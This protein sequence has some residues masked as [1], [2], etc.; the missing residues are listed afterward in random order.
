MT[1]TI[2]GTT[3][4]SGE[5]TVGRSA[6]AD[7]LGA[8]KQRGLAG[9]AGTCSTWFYVGDLDEWNKDTR[10]WD[11]NWE[12]DEKVL[13]DTDTHNDVLFQVVHTIFTGLRHG[14]GVRGASCI[15]VTAPNGFSMESPLSHHP[16]VL[17]WCCIYVKPCCLLPHAVDLQLVKTNLLAW[18]CINNQAELEGLKSEVEEKKEQL[19]KYGFSDCS[20][21][22]VWCWEI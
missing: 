12:K 13:K 10:W 2:T 1:T 9:T 18:R 5:E 19:Q 4:T 8:S 6:G 21:I 3:W 22:C 14:V 11:E 15:M 7:G 16:P 20:S 17:Q